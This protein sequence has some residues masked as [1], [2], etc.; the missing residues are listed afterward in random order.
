MTFTT[1]RALLGNASRYLS[2]HDAGDVAEA[3]PPLC[4]PFLHDSSPFSVKVVRAVD[5]CTG[6]TVGILDYHNA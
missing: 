1:G 2:S 5:G 3:K 6:R 4:T